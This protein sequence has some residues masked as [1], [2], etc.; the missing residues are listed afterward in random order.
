MTKLWQSY[1]KV[2]TQ[3]YDQI[4][5]QIYEKAITQI[6]DKVMTKLWHL[7]LIKRGAEKSRWTPGRHFAGAG[8]R[9]YK[10]INLGINI[11]ECV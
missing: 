6:Y 1:D 9:T 4:V 5:K 2:I 8:M 3:S 7:W 11:L 10:H